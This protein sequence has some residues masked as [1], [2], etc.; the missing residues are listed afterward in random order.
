MRV[1]ASAPAGAGALPPPAPA[2]QRTY[3]DQQA[4]LWAA[5]A[6]GKRETVVE[7][8]PGDRRFAAKD[9]HD[10]PFYD[11]L[12]QSYLLAAR[13]RRR[14]AARAACQGA[15]ALRGAPMDRRDVPGELS[16]H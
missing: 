14:R 15:R 1:L 7:P 11:Y 6:S 8:E 13:Y 10:N 4:K 16:G 12:K 2:L 5:L 9:W 3:L